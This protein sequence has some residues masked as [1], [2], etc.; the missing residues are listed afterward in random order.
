[1]SQIAKLYARLVADPKTVT[2]FDD[3][4]RLLKAFGFILNRTRGSHQVFVHPDCPRPL[5]L[6]P[7][8]KDAKRYQVGQFLDMIEEYGLK[9][10][11]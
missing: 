10:D 1:M 6:Q 5:V 11:E 3:F 8:G 9:L 4:T 7:L 2:R